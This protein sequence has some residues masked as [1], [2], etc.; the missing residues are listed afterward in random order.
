MD[1]GLP[2]LYL[3]VVDSKQEVGVTLHG[4][5]RLRLGKKVN[6]LRLPRNRNAT[7][8]EHGAVGHGV[9]GN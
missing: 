2:F 9:A 3:Y 1:S 4:E 5:K 8:S 7:P 6:L